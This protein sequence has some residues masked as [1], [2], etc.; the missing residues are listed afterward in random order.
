MCG[1]YTLF[2]ED[3]TDELRRRV[4]ELQKKNG[5]VMT[6]EIFPTNVAPVLI[7][8]D[9]KPVPMAYTWGLASPGRTGVVINARAETVAEKP[10]FRTCMQST[11]CVVPSTGFY[12]WT[13][14]ARMQKYRFRLPKQKALYMAGLWTMGEG[15]G[16]F[17]IVT[18]A[19][20]AS[21]REVHHR[22]PVILD[23]EEIED[24]L[25]DPAAAAEILQLIPPE[26][27]KTAVDAEQ[28]RLW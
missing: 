7:A 21:M 8:L 11:R 5:E 24:W 1:R 3:E 16:R 19:A 25:F 28:M 18:T 13:K 27:E 2:T 14:D 22:M 10:M 23:E 4:E 26:L 15:G 20:N 12:E 6:G 9:G 17:A